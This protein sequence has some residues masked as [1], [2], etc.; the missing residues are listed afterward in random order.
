MGT[1]FGIAIAI[2]IGGAEMGIDP[3][4]DVGANRNILMKIRLKNKS[5]NQ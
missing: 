4:P 2:G 1:R 3:A 5:A